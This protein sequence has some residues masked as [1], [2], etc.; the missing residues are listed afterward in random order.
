MFK[1]ICDKVKYFIS[2]KEVV[3]QIV[4]IKILER[5]EWI[6]IIFYLLKKLTFHNFIILIKSVDDKN[7][8]KYYYNLLFRK[9][10]A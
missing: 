2:K 6:D 9:R 5:S 7:E 3:L 10:F 1:K 4:L 8:N